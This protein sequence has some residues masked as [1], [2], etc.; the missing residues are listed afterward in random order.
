MMHGQKSIKKKKHTILFTLKH[1][2][3]A[4]ANLLL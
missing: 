4:G 3:Q 1:K 2:S